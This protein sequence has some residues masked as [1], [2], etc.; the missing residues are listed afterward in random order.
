MLDHL[1]TIFL[2]SFTTAALAAPYDSLSLLRRNVSSTSPTITTIVHSANGNDVSSSF[3]TLVYWQSNTVAPN[4]SLTDRQA[5]V[6]QI[7][8]CQ[9][10]F[11]QFIGSH[12]KHSDG[13][14]VS[15]REYVVH[16]QRNPS[17]RSS[18]RINN[19]EPPFEPS[20][21]TEEG[22]CS[23]NEICVNSMSHGAPGHG[24][25]TCVE[26]KDFLPDEDY[27]QSFTQ[28]GTQ[29]HVG[30]ALR[31][32]GAKKAVIVFSEQNGAVIELD[33]LEVDT[34]A[35]VGG[36]LQKQLCKD[37]FGMR[38]KKAAADADLMQIEA[39]LIATTLAAGII[40]VSVLA[41]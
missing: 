33:S 16:C 6:R 5:P 31:E 1:A 2:A 34:G 7:N 3:R 32:I 12:C 23:E 21:V 27:S 39:T 20:I 18:W 25:A 17:W 38:T 11:A 28:E 40:W 15:I 29:Q 35:E 36:R 13:F 41:G 37:C 4:S 26:M 9:S 10:H 19:T 30:D 14:D 8:T 24:V 22:S